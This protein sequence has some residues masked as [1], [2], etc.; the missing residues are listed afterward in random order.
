MSVKAKAKPAPASSST[1][2]NDDKKKR[3]V[4]SRA[5]QAALVE[6]MIEA[7]EPYTPDNLAFHL[8]EKGHFANSQKRTFS[9]AQVQS[10]ARQ[11][12]RRSGGEL[13]QP[14]SSRMG[15]NDIEAMIEAKRS[16]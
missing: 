12:A 11:L 15:K 5:A 13:R 8:K 14:F 3:V 10:K 7:Q 4:W 6:M 2:N 1:S 9:A 16:I